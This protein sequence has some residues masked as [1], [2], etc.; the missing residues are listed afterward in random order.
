MSALSLLIYP[1]TFV[2][3]PDYLPITIYDPKFSGIP[4]WNF[5]DMSVV[6]T[7][8]RNFY[9]LPD[10]KTANKK[11]RDDEDRH[12]LVLGVW[13]VLPNS[14]SQRLISENRTSPQ[15][16]AK[17]LGEGDEPVMVFFHGRGTNRPSQARFYN[18]MAGINFH[19][20]AIDWRGFGDSTGKPSE[21]GLNA[22]SHAIYSYA[23]KWLQ[24]R[25][26]IV[27]GQSLGTAISSYTV[28]SE[29][30]MSE[31]TG[32]RP[33]ILPNLSVSG[34]LSTLVLNPRWQDSQLEIPA[35]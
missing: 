33:G 16:M 21:D 12:Q 27:F 26:L 25:K 29:E 31:R 10:C 24:I 35:L 8:A 32:F 28:T 19:V 22:D 13:H 14:T 4:S 2:T 11:P 1:L 18:T 6:N 3:F 30:C 34:G 20:L 7:L 17:S 15:D 23:Q 9:L 5:T